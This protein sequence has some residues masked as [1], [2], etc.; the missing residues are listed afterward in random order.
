MKKILATSAILAMSAS[1]LAGSTYGPGPG[2]NIPDNNAAGIMTSIMVP[3]SFTITD[4]NA[5][6]RGLTHTWAGDISI[7]LTHNATTATLVNRIGRN[8]SGFGDSS[9]LGGDYTFDSE[10]VNDI[11][12]AAAATTG[13]VPAGTYYTSGAN[14]AANNNA[15]AVFN[16]MDAAGEWKIMITDHAGGDTGSFGGWTLDIVPEPTSLSLLAL[17]GLALI[18]RR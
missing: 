4:V 17:G 15:L 7:T 3:D 1:A 11:W 13:P 2:G 14:S 8:A 5:T 16:G 9:D 18:R 12:A 6:V 10:S